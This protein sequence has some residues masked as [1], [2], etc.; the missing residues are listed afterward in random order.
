MKGLMEND[1]KIYIFTT[2]GRNSLRLTRKTE[3]NKRNY[4]EIFSSCLDG[5]MNFHL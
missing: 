3:G 2:V 4:P 1:N 5:T